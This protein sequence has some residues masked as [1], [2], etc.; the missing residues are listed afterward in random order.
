MRDVDEFIKIRA[1]VL[2]HVSA[3]TNVRLYKALY[4]HNPPILSPQDKARYDRGAVLNREIALYGLQILRHYKAKVVSITSPAGTKSSQIELQTQTELVH[5]GGKPWYFFESRPIEGRTLHWQW[6]SGHPVPVC[7]GIWLDAYADSADQVRRVSIQ[8]SICIEGFT[9]ALR[10][11]PAGLWELCEEFEIDGIKRH[12]LIQPDHFN[13][14]GG[15]IEWTAKHGLAVSNFAF[16]EPN[17]GGEGNSEEELRGLTGPGWELT[18]V[19][20]KRILPGRDGW[21][22]GGF[23]LGR[24]MADPDPSISE[25]ARM[26]QVIN[27]EQ[28]IARAK[29]WDVLS[30]QSP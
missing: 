3:D 4:Q 26:L 19:P 7:E 12:L 6:T 28:F 10:R 24:A 9:I 21:D 22:W 20:G 2:K 8:Q 5:I 17:T 14:F 16:V 23:A 15:Q 29:A 18:N 13:L 27:P 25:E 1:D 30:P 11:T